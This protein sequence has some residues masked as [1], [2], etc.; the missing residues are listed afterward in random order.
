MGKRTRDPEIDQ[1][2]RDYWPQYGAVRT[3]LELEARGHKRSLSRVK[4][5]AWE[6][7]L[8]RAAW[9]QAEDAILRAGIAVHAAAPE[10]S[11]TLAEAG[12]DRDV[13]AVVRRAR[14]LGIWNAAERSRA[15][16]RAWNQARVAESHEQLVGGEYRVL[17][18][19][20]AWLIRRWHA[21]GDSAAYLAQDMKRPLWL[22][23]AIIRREPW[24]ERWQAERVARGLEAAA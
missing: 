3:Q 12:W 5:L 8:E 18:D 13:V 21:Q 11:R 17:T 24:Q 4:G 14:E 20:T 15:R 22:V 16:D 19:S 9:D 6:L 1:I 23:Q 10:I 7:W 2:M